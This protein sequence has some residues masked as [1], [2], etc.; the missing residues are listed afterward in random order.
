MF[1]ECHAPAVPNCR[2]LRRLC[3]RY[4]IAYHDWDTA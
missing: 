4:G 1:I 2:D 3:L